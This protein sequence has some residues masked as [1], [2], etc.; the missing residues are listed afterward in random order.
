MP[1]PTCCLKKASES[2]QA[3]DTTTTEVETQKTEEHV[4]PCHGDAISNTS[5][6]KCYR[7]A[8]QLPSQVKCKRAF[9]MTETKRC[10]NESQVQ[11]SFRSWLKQMHCKRRKLWLLWVN[12]KFEYYWIFNILSNYILLFKG[13][14]MVLLFIWGENLVSE[15]HILKHLQIKWCSLWNLLNKGRGY[16][17]I[18]KMKQNCL[19]DNND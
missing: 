15:K 13:I 17:R 14:M 9:R 6:G 18:V 11:S 3:S 4:K 16:V 5:L 7:T 10:D 19:W 1:S 8:N 2:D 12:W